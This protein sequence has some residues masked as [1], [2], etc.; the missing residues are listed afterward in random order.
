MQSY[1]PLRYPGG[2][3]RLASTI[4]S[5]LEANGL[6]DIE[7]AEP[8]AGGASVGLG[9]LFG[10]YAAAIHINDLSRPVYAFWHSVLN[11]ADQLCDRIKSAKLTMAEWRRQRDVLRLGGKA[12]LADLGFAT[13]YLNRTNRSGVI[14]GGV[15]GGQGQTGDWGIDARFNRDTLIKRIEKIARY[16]N[17]IHLYRSDALKFTGEV[18]AELGDKSFVFYDPPYIE[19]GSKLYLNDYTLDGHRALAKRIAKLKQHWVVT[20]DIAAR[21]HGLYP[22]RRHIVYDLHYTAHDRY[23]GREVMFFSDSL[24]LPEANEMLWNTMHFNRRMSR[25]D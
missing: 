7:Y 22:D 24:E 3:K 13:F 1:S 8:Y 15:I 11:G 16:R 23:K 18:I 21:R 9:L 20:Y 25:L 12:K 19:S 14:S 17:R 2:K 10:E 4:S 5:L 6:R